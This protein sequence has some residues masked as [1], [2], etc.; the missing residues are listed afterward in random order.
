[1]AR[2][3]FQPCRGRQISLAAKRLSRGSGTSPGRDTAAESDSGRPIVKLT[4]NGSY[5][6]TSLVMAGYNR[7]GTSTGLKPG[8]EFLAV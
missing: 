8:R 2:P 4:D 5:R 3:A 6:D 1:M 7:V